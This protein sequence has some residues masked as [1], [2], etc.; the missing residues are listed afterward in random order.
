MAAP[1]RTLKLSILGDV[2]NLV[3]SLK[4][5][6]TATDD[7]TKTLDNFGKKAAL[8]FSAAATAALFPD[9]RCVR[10]QYE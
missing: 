5:G 2:S 10:T 3:S 6:E 1:S 8:A 7:Y 9:C 4:K